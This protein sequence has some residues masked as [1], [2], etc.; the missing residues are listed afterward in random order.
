MINRRSFLMTTFAYLGLIRLSHAD[1]VQRFDEFGVLKEN[2]IRHLSVRDS[3]NLIAAHPDVVV[4]D[5]RTPREYRAG[6]IEG[7]INVNYFSLSFKKNIEALDN[8]KA[9]LVH[10]KSGH[11]SGRAAPIMKK[12]GIVDVLHMDGGFDAWKK[13]DFDVV[14]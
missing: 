1:D 12:A 3:K 5:V 13:A 7:A 8:S 6:H 4:L 9:Y 11:R 2:G 14:R 10:C